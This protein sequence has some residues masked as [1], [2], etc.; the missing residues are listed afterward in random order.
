MSQRNRIGETLRSA[1]EKVGLSVEEAA[2]KAGI[3]TQYVRL[4]EGE[5]NVGVGVADELYLIPFFRRYAAFLGVDTADLLPEF[6]GMVQEMTGEGSPP[7]RLTYRKPWAA[8]W[9]PLALIVTIALAGFAIVWRSPERP[10][11]IVDASPASLATKSSRA[12]ATIE[13]TAPPATPPGVL[14]GPSVQPA[15][16]A[17]TLPTAQPPTDQPTPM[18]TEDRTTPEAPQSNAPVAAAHELRITAV[19]ETWISIGIDDEP[20]K[21]VMLR[22]GESRTWNAASGFGLTVGN[23]GGITVALD[24]KELPPLGRSGDVVRVQ[25][26]K[27][28]ATPAH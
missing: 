15:D 27:G 24:G 17:I 28:E 12:V 5:S 14:E 2:G 13:A 23:A 22:P 20:R 4:L 6:V 19:E 8:L 3:P 1:R 21:S 26:P 7:M 18:T 25:L 10:R 16:A 9:R 11:P